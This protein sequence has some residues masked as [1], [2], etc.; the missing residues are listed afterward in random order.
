M[1]ISQFQKYSQK[2]NTV[3]NNVLLMLSR[4]NDLKV[5][6]YKS[7]IEK[8]SDGGQSYEPQANFLQQVGSNRGIIDGF[9]EVKAS[10]IVIETKLSQRELIK[11]L[12]KY[13]DVFKKGVQNQLWH[14]S[15]NSYSEE[16]VEIINEKLKQEYPQ[17]PIEFNNLL[18]LNLIENL[19]EIYEE[20]VHDYELKL[21]YE[22]FRDY[23]Y[24]QRLVNDSAYKLLFVP[25]GWSYKWNLK[26]KMYFCP[27]NWHKQDFSFFGLYK[28]K[29]VRSFTK[30]ENIIQANYDFPSNSLT[31][32]SKNY[33]DRQ[34]ER[35]RSALLD[36]GESQ[37]DLKYYIL[38][39]NEFYTTDFKKG[40]KGGIQSFRYK[41][42]RHFIEEENQVY[43]ENQN[44]E[45][46]AEILKNK[47][48]K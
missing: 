1:R 44:T 19:E 11:K 20:N 45:R 22:D 16:E 21:L 14:L 15:S 34:I 26:H 38:P 5:E 28:Y 9:I 40:S 12:T 47:V 30:V 27:T 36:F 42:L 10:K 3:T 13:G 2:E 48:W 23:C 4:L 29:S 24:E 32:F 37:S 35:L 43:L 31:I 39:E 6:Y 41:D 7:M 25:T 46:I 18:F 33:T 8:L 17:I